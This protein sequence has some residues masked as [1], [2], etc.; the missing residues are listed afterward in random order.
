MP[1]GTAPIYSWGLKI[2]STSP[3]LHLLL[4]NNPTLTPKIT[5][6]FVFQ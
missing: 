1:D 5:D 6:C 3:V 4:K 2:S